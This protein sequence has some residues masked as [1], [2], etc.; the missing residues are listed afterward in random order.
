MGSR[1]KVSRPILPTRQIP[2]PATLFDKWQDRSE[3]LKGNAM[4]IDRHFYYH[5]DL[6]VHQSVPFA[7]EREQRLKDGEYRRMTP[8][9]KRSGMPPT[10]HAMMRS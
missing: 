3:T 5:Y 6:K 4:S 10:S 2:E 1:P 9:Q 8:G 7:T